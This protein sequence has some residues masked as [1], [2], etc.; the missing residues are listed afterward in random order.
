MRKTLK[1]LLLAILICQLGSTVAQKSVPPF[2]QKYREG[3]VLENNFIYDVARTYYV[4]AYDL[5]H[6]SRQNKNIQT[7]IKHKIQR[8][9]CY[10]M[11]YHLVNQADM[12]ELMQDFESAGKFLSDAIRFANDENLDVRE[13]DSLQERLE[14]VMKTHQLCEMLN[15]VNKYNENGRFTDAKLLFTELTLQSSELHHYW[16]KYNFQDSF[17]HKFD[18]LST[19]LTL[20]RSISQQYRDLYSADFVL[21]D[22]HFRNMLD[23]TAWENGED[24]ESDISFLFS[25]DT[26]GVEDRKVSSTYNKKS[27]TDSL[28]TA[29]NMIELQQPHRYGFSLPTGD[30]ISH[31]IVS[32]KKSV[33]LTKKK[34]HYIYGDQEFEKF[35][36]NLISNNLRSAPEGKYVFVFHKN[37]IDG[38]LSVH[39]DLSKAKGSKARRWSK[40][41]VIVF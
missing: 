28:I 27:F 17:I 36:K 7:K 29:L 12:L 35:F 19:F 26:N 24:F 14:I 31:H 10:G 13:I 18:S 1:I 22:N 3:E 40:N 39:A 4:E 2:E 32:S 21:M 41:K 37:E 30:V 6:A 20:N 33:T 9:D 23:K 38:H 25:I 16:E 34:N 11:F 15:S 8:M 5:A